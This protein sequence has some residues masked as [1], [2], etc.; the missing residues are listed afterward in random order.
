[1]TLLP[2]VMLTWLKSLP[3]P[4]VIL[5]PAPAA[6]VAT[7]APPLLLIVP[8]SVIAP[9]L[10]IFR[11]PTLLV[12]PPAAMLSAPL[13]VRLMLPLALLLALKPDTVF[14]LFSV[15]PATL[16][17]V[18]VPV[19]ESVPPAPSLIVA[20]ALLAVRL[21]APP[22]PALTA[23]VVRLIE[24]VLLIVTLPPPV[25]PIPVIVSGAAVSVSEI[26]PPVVFVALKLA[27]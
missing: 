2:V 22:P 23:A 11:L 8:V 18:N 12:M 24:P 19:V 9:V 1:M 10:V 21:I 26:F 16:E 20:P 5:L 15:V 14:A 25:W 4:S 6:N 17:V 7:L 3:P 13:L 27:T